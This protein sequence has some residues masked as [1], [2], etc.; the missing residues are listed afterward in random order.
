[1][2]KVSIDHVLLVECM[3]WQYMVQ[4]VNSGECCIFYPEHE[5]KTL[6]LSRTLALFTSVDGDEIFNV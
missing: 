1:M 6:S 2:F 4:I 3:L 5:F